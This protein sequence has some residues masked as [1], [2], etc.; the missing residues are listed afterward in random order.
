MPST[1][2]QPPSRLSKLWF[3]S[4]DDEVLDLV[5]LGCA[6]A[7]AVDRPKPGPRREQQRRHRD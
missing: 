3:S 5:E 2:S 4:Y 7:D 6:V 1:R